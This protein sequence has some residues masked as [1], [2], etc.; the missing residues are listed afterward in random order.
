MTQLTEDVKAVNPDQS[1]D[2]GVAA[3]YF[4]ADMFISALKIVY[5]EGGAAAITPEN[6]RAAAA[7]QTWA[8]DGLIG[9]TTYPESTVKPT[10]SCGTLA[11][12]DGTTWKTVTEFSCS[13]RSF[14]VE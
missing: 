9:P 8:I 10:P 6:V 12:S 4:S 2:L 3:G 13:D 5:E 7:N 1:L 11:K 14:P